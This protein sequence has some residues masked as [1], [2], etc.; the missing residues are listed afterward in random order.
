MKKVKG[1][2]GT[3]TLVCCLGSFKKTSR[4]ITCREVCQHLALRFPLISPCLER[5]IVHPCRVLCSNSLFFIYILDRVSLCS[6]GCPGIHYVGQ[7]GLILTESLTCASQVL[8]FKGKQTTPSFIIFSL[9]PPLS[10][11]HHP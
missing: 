9:L 1:E 8:R 11:L 5:S 2:I 10:C 7:A 3:I 6:L 4:P